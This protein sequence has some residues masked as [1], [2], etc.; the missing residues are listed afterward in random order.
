MFVKDIVRRSKDCEKLIAALPRKDESS[1]R[2]G[3]SKPPSNLFPSSLVV[4]HPL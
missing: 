4:C 3:Q 1:T 2:V